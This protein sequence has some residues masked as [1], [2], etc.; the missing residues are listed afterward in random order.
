MAQEKTYASEIS[1]AI[2][3]LRTAEKALFLAR[4]NF[5]STAQQHTCGIAIS[6]R[7]NTIAVDAIDLLNPACTL[8]E[9][10]NR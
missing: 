4:N 9:L 1:R 7:I 10:K 2:R 5:P 8:P 3:A 6:R